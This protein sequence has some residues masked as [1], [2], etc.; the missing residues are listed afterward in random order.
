[1]GR[2]VPS[3]FSS[4]FRARTDSRERRGYGVSVCRTAGKNASKEE[5][6]LGDKSQLRKLAGCLYTRFAADSC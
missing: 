6:I 4:V 3:S 2:F 5:K 1:M